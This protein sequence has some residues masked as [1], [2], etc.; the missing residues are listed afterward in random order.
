MND[1]LHLIER[2]LPE[3]SKAQRKISSFLIEHS[4]SAVGM[5]AA[6]LAQTVGTSESTVVRFATELGYPGYPELQTALRESVRDSLTSVQRMELAHTEDG[7]P[8][9]AHS[10]RTDIENIKRT[11]ADMD[12]GVLDRVAERLAGARRIYILGTRSASSLAMFLNFYLEQLFDD[13][14]L[15]QASSGS[16]I[17]DQLFPVGKND[18]VVGISFPRYSRRTVDAMDFSRK[19]GAFVCAITDGVNSPLS[20]LADEAIFAYNEN[21][22]FADSLVAPMAV[23][24]ALIAS[25]VAKKP[26]EFADRLSKLE[27]VWS[28]Y[29]VY[30]RG[31]APSAR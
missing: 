2:H 3:C 23:L 20:D 30:S 9:Y 6:K 18:V 7:K 14:R 17:L 12:A 13:V 29:G 1:A 21:E 31:A 4:A 28:E 27:E 22:S 25:V 26:E 11:L 8:A 16:E 24:N 5:T 15:V 19:K 10:M